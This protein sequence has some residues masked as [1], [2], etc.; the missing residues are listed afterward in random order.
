MVIDT[1]ALLAIL[2]NE[3]E[4]HHFNE[5]IASF[6]K[7]LLSAGTYLE[8]AIVIQSKFGDKGI[9]NLQLFLSTAEIEII[10]FDRDQAKAASRAYAA[11]GKGKHP[12][13]L[14]FGDCMSYALAEQTGEPL[15]FKGD[16]FTKTDVSSLTHQ[17]F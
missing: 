2:F 8:T 17:Q 14:N 10:S 11:F 1:S 9:H 3:P 6:P 13:G 15:L 7:R 12:A 4:R 5:L 16:D